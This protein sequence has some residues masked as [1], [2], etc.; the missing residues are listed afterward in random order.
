M[1]AAVYET[2]GGTEVV[3]VRE[4]P[5]PDPGP[6]EVRVRIALAG[7]NP[8]DWKVI[9]RAGPPG[10]APFAVPCQDG[11]GTIDAVG[12]GVDSSRIGERVWLFFA[13]HERRWG[14][15]AEF[16]VLPAERA[17]P[18][19]EQASFELG[20]SL[21]IPALTAFHCLCAGGPLSGAR[22]LVAGGAGAVGHAAIQLA[23]F[24]GATT[25]VATASG[26]EKANLAQRAGADPVVNYRE[27]GAADAIR[28]A[29]PD[30][31]ERVVEV[32][33]ASNLEL[34]LTV[35]APHAV[36]STYADDG[37]DPAL[38]VRRLMGPNLQLRFVLIYT[39]RPAELRA[40][41]EGTREAVAAGALSALPTHRYALEQAPQALAAVEGGKLGKVLIEP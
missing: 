8:T 6:G 11:A 27:R 14:T 9:R 7:V 31:I 41:V 13:A 28:R 29:V 20:A 21:G 35:C 17:I 1:R 40:A 23:H 5:T 30:G 3:R 24:L 26:P 33:L 2:S 32:S 36:I 18:L 22:V 39:I 38:P 37:G 25:V 15:A 16:S 4:V 34:D 19:P 12:E 10:G